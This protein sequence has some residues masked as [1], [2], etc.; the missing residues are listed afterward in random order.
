[1]EYQKEPCCGQSDRTLITNQPFLAYYMVVTIMCG[2]M[3]TFCPELLTQQR[4]LPLL[5]FEPLL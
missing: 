2:N 1:M 3:V 4:K 5:S